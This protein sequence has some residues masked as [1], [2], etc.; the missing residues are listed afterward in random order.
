MEK[1]VARVADCEGWPSIVAA[2]K[3]TNEDLAAERKR[4]SHGLRVDQEV[5]RGKKNGSSKAPK[6]LVTASDPGKVDSQITA[7]YRGILNRWCQK[8]SCDQ[9]EIDVR[10]LS[11]QPASIQNGGE[12]ERFLATV[13]SHFAD[14]EFV[15]VGED[16]EKRAALQLGCRD[17]ATQIAETTSDAWLQ[18]EIAAHDKLPLADKDG[19]RAEQVLGLE[20]EL[21]GEA[22]APPTAAASAVPEAN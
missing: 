8:K 2:L 18:E 13:T 12:G 6:K 9:C 17:L 3:L 22:D 4:S 14:Q 7:N 16:C 21:A 15:G 19:K 5:K 10:S 11:D 20:G 1:P